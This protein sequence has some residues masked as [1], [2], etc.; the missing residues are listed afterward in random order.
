MIMLILSVGIVENNKRLFPR[1]R[2]T[3]EVVSPSSAI[4]V[5]ARHAAPMFPQLIST[6]MD[7]PL[8]L[9]SSDS[10]LSAFVPTPSSNSPFYTPTS[11]TFMSYPSGQNLPGHKLPGRTHCASADKENAKNFFYQ[12]IVSFVLMV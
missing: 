5:P 8:P 3:E 1:C 2:L 9:S 4:P 12:N 10:F 7:P 6:P 11:N